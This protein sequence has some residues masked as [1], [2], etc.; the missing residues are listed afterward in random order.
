VKASIVI[1]ALNEERRLGGLLSDLAAQTR[2]PDEVLVVDAGSTD[3]TVE[4]ARR[5]PYAEVLGATP[6]VARGR[7]VGGMRAGGDVVVFFDADV[8]VQRDFLAGLLGEMERRRLDVA[9]P[10][11]VPEGGASPAVRAFHAF[12]NAIF[13]AVQ[14][15]APS[16][17][18]HCI[19]VRGDLFRESRGFDP[20]LKFDD[21]EL[22]RRLSRG[23]RFGVVGEKVYVSDRRY[24]E[25]GTLNTFM[26]HLLMSVFFALGKFEWANRVEYEF[27]KHTS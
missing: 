11:Y 4:V 18:G 12:F 19:A 26:R 10:A 20:G 16:G 17:A 9:C 3:G 15:I 13:K 8:R 22:V 2:P 14:G 5:F 24:R 21:I 7:N 6:P 25:D 23:R 27:G 1:P